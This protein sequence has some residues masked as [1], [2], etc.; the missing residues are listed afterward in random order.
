MWICSSHIFLHDIWV[1]LTGRIFTS[2]LV[3]GQ[4]YAILLG[5]REQSKATKPLSSLLA[6]IPHPFLCPPPTSVSFYN[7][8]TLPLL[9]FEINAMVSVCKV[10]KM[11]D[12][13]RFC[14]NFCQST[15][16]PHYLLS[17]TLCSNNTGSVHGFLNMYCVFS[18]LLNRFVV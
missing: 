1:G 18:T 3:Q 4:V 13:R 17:F 5:P 12:T 2:Y 15:N 8:E 6:Y 16:E 9:N 14:H 10:H 7:I 11:L